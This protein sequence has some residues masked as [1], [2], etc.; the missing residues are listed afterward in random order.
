[1]SV[2]IL[3]LMINRLNDLEFN[4]PKYIIHSVERKVF[5]VF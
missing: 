1:M 2:V 5:A 3:Q 4:L